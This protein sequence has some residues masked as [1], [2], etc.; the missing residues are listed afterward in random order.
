V[1]AVLALVSPKAVLLVAGLAA[2]LA[3]LVY[4][5]GRLRAAAR[6]RG[7]GASELMSFFETMR[8]DGV[9]TEQEYRAIKT[10]VTRRFREE[11]NRNGEP[12]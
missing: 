9:L 6:E 5:I 2:S 3:V 8:S 1:V 7:P 10:H 11:L 12:G 4:V